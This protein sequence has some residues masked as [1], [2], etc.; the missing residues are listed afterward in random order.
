MGGNP[1]AVAVQLHAIATALLGE[2]LC[3][4]QQCRTDAA[5][6]HSGIDTQIADAAEIAGQGQLHDEVQRDQP[7]HAAIL[8]GHQQRGIGV[9]PLLRQAFGEKGFGVGVA[10]LLEQGA[11]GRQVCRAGVAN[12]HQTARSQTCLSFRARVWM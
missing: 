1:A 8:L 7:Y 3:R 6:T 12:P 11:D 4:L 5:G 2:P 9:R 10:Q